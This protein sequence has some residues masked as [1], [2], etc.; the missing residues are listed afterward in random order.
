MNLDPIADPGYESDTG[1]RDIPTCANFEQN[2]P[3]QATIHVAKSLNRKGRA[4]CRIMASHGWTHK[5]IAYIFRVSYMSVQRAIEN[6]KYSPRDRVEEDYA[7]VD[8]EFLEKYPPR[9]Q[10]HLAKPKEITLVET[11][12]DEWDLGELT[13][14][15]RPQRTAKA[16]CQSRIRMVAEDENDAYAG[17]S[18]YVSEEPDAPP[19]SQKR[20]HEDY[21][22]L[23]TSNPNAGVQERLA[24]LVPRKTDYSLDQFSWTSGETRTLWQRLLR[25]SIPG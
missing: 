25:P 5:S 9:H 6:I 2:Q 8:S 17:P 4:I 21:P 22:A 24:T 13:S 11:S 7:R 19:T 12:E 20:I 10:Y 1:E 3:V 14:L 23:V 16:Q 15:G 18:R